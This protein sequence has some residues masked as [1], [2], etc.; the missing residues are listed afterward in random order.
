MRRALS[1]RESR[2]RALQR[3]ASGRQNEQIRFSSS[4]SFVYR[5][6]SVTLE[7][8]SPGDSDLTDIS[9]WN[10]TVPGTVSSFPTTNYI[11]TNYITTDC[12]ATNTT[13]PIV[14]YK[15][16]SSWYGPAQGAFLGTSI[17]DVADVADVAY[18][19]GVPLDFRGPHESQETREWAADAE[20]LRAAGKRARRLLLES[21][22]AEQ[23]AEFRKHR[24]R[25]RFFVTAPSGNEYMIEMGRYGNVYLVKD[26]EKTKCLC[27]HPEGRIP[28]EDTILAQKLHLEAGL[29]EPFLKIANEHCEGTW[30][31]EIAA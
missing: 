20:A 2:R 1:P 15:S 21:L 9:H 10:I 8:S 19:S 13:T 4:P 27:A 26:G 31:R 23:L 25:R 6:P 5:E 17:A 3:S 24:K 30:S 12:I 18:V 28:N 22:D 11:T 14:V 29:E 7:E 16:V